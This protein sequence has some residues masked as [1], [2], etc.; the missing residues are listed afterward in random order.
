[1]STPFLQSNHVAFGLNPVA[2]F[3]STA[4]TT[5]VVNMEN[6]HSVV[7]LVFW[8]VG[9]TGTNTLT[10]LA[11]DDFV[12][13]N[14]TAIPFRYRRVSGAINA[15]DTHAAVTDATTAGF[16]TTA[17]SHQCYVIEV[18]SKELGDTGYENIQLK[19]VTAVGGAILG[20]V[21]IIQSQPR[22]ADATDTTIS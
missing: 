7:F 15:G 18:D 8:G 10:V 17:G 22:Y 13:T 3:L 2:D 21:L 14:T 1:M 19:S 4:A 16:A 12:P 9:T 6:Y 20:G 11:C 5:D